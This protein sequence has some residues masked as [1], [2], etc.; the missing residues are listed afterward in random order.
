MSSA[1]SAPASW[2][3]ARWNSLSAQ[4]LP[5]GCA[6]KRLVHD[7]FDLAFSGGRLRIDLEAH[8]RQIGHRLRPDRSDERP[9]GCARGRGDLRSPD[10]QIHDFELGRPRVT[11]SQLQAFRRSSAISSP[12]ATAFTACAAPASRPRSCAST[13]RTIPFGW[14]GVL[15]D[16]PPVSDELIYVSTSAASRS[17][18]SAAARAAATTCSARSPEQVDRVARRALLGGAERGAC[19][20]TRRQALVTGPS[21]EKSI[22]PLR[23]FVAEPLSLRAP[24]PR[25][26]CRP[27][28]AAHRG[29][30][31]NLA[32]SDVHYL[33]P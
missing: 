10:V 22:A 28:R 25:R 8:H 6:R 32:A 1:A 3:A 23:S 13:R 29:E 30:G 15:S 9:D 5:A 16:T 33:Q 11:W 24:V 20:G 14:L 4:A 26:R 19:P 7:G 12:A 31:L 17:A 27:H 21:I 18:A 2:R